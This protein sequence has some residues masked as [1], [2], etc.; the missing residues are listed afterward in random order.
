MWTDIEARGMNPKNSTREALHM[1][2]IIVGLF[3]L[4]ILALPQVASA[5]NFTSVFQYSAKFV[6]GRV[7]SEQGLGVVPGHY[8]TTI[9]LR[10]VA[11]KNALAYRAV[12]TRTNIT[13]DPLAEGTPTD[14]SIRFNFDRDGG[15]GIICS[16]IKNLFNVEQQQGFI[17]G[18]VLIYSNGQ[19]DVTDVVTAEPCPDGCFGVSSIQIYQ[20]AQRGASVVVK[21]LPNL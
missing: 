3:G 14:F 9:N 15:L 8:G 18:F 17:E 1:K 13:L 21:P 5:Q 2:K 10:A 7:N 16:D 20:V 19:L 4:L 11:N 6:C 12:A